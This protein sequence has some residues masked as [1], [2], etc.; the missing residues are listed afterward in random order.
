MKIL[1]HKHIYIV[2]K[3]THTSEMERNMQEKLSDVT[4]PP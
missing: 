1:Y 4:F 3:K 2:L